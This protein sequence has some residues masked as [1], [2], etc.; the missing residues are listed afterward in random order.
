MQE[1]LVNRL[2]PSLLPLHTRILGPSVT[3]AAQIYERSVY[4]RI[5]MHIYVYKKIYQ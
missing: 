5:C 1:H 3:L 4:M 2:L